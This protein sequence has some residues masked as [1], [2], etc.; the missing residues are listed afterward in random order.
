MSVVGEVSA[1]LG[2]V[3]AGFS[4]AKAIRTAV[5]DYQDAKNDIGSLADDIETTLA[6]VSNLDTL[7]RDNDITPTFDQNGIQIARKCVK[8]AG[9]IVEDL[10]KLLTLAGVPRDPHSKIKSEDIKV[11]CFERLGWLRIKSRVKVKREELNG[12]RLEV[13]VAKTCKDIRAATSPAELATLSAIIAG[14][15]RSRRKVERDVGGLP[16]NGGIDHSQTSS[17]NIF[18]TQIQV[19]RNISGPPKTS[20]KV[21]KEEASAGVRPANGIFDS[22]GN[23]SEADAGAEQSHL[24]AGLDLRADPHLVIQNNQVGIEP[25]HENITENAVEEFKIQQRDKLIALAESIAG[26]QERMFKASDGRL[27]E[28]ELRKLIEEHHAVELAETLTEWLPGVQMKL[29]PMIA[30]SVVD[31]ELDD[32]H[33]SRPTIKWRWER[34]EKNKPTNHAS[35]K[36]PPQK[37]ETGPYAHLL[38]T[39]QIDEHTS[40]EPVITPLVLPKDVKNKTPQQTARLWTK[41][42]RRTHSAITEY[43]CYRKEFPRGYTWRLLTRDVAETSYFVLFMAEPVLDRSEAQMAY[44]YAA[45]AQPPPPPPS[46]PLPAPFESYTQTAHQLASLS[47]GSPS[48]PLSLFPPV[49]S[50]AAPPET[51]ANAQ[52][53]SWDFWTSANGREHHHGQLPVPTEGAGASLEHADLFPSEA[54]EDFVLSGCS[55]TH[56]DEEVSTEPGS[57]RYS[58]EESIDDAELCDQALLRFTGQKLRG[59]AMDASNDENASDPSNDSEAHLA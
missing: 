49:P 18:T 46:A 3:E 59:G 36:S 11:S 48:W 47:A 24:H 1:V 37:S 32:Q 38:V 22:G 51:S 23:G 45:L 56:G 17:D 42:G 15:E 57:E 26:T 29:K 31:I 43:L 33:R 54:T 27:A 21:S 30:K 9:R 35:K 2:L 55:P 5:Q 50:M 10:L 6:L 34:R 13:L 16:A 52:T 28:L 4:L 44:P 40:S 8:S 39:T 12:V 20:G 25:Q 53:A 14:L 19:T 7:I 58:E 41:M